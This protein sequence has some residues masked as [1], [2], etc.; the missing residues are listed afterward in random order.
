LLPLICYTLFRLLAPLAK[1]LHNFVGPLFFVSIIVTF[2]VFVRDNIPRQEDARW[3]AHFG[4]LLGGKEIPSHRFNALEK[5]WFWFGLLVLGLVVSGSGFVLDFPNFDQT[6]Y[7]M[8]T[9]NIVHVIGAT[10]FILG[11]MGHIYM[12]TIGMTGAYRAM[13]DGYVD[14]SWAREHHELWYN[15]IKAGKMP[16]DAE[17]FPGGPVRRSAQG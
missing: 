5:L 17:A 6:R 14:E 10:L 12:G 15:D 3:I 13:R 7:T 2:L 4:G 11:G 1:T 16:A 9:A 8:Q